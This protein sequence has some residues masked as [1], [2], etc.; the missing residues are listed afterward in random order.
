ML[1]LHVNQINYFY[2]NAI[3]LDYSYLPLIEHEKTLD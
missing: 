1:Q 3:Q 2:L